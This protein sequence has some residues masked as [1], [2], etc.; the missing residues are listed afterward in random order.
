MLL[1]LQV[2]GELT[3]LSHG[4]GDQPS[5]LHKRVHPYPLSE[6][7]TYLKIKTMLCQDHLY[8]GPSN[9]SRT[10][11]LKIMQE[12]KNGTRRKREGGKKEWMTGN[13]SKE[14]WEGLNLMT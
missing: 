8:I 1:A 2:S 11:I 10:L 13:C 9:F 3:Y 4:Y 6:H 7:G 12:V 14:T 5:S